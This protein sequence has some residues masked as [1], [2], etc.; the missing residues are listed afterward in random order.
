[1]DVLVSV[2]IFDERA[3]LP[4]KEH[5]EGGGHISNDP[6]LEAV[7]SRTG[8]TNAIP[9][10]VDVG[11]PEIPYPD[12]KELQKRGDPTLRATGA[13]S[14]KEMAR[15]GASYTLD[16]YDDSVEFSASKLDAKGRW[17]EDPEK[18]KKL[19]ADTPVAELAQMILDDWN[20]RLTAK[21]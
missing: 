16:W 17:V 8:L 9:S 3:Y 19:P 13:K 7:L 2:I 20:S 21:S 15:K 14:W 5:M 4:T 12:E 6:V 11:N 18:T 10:A 1:M